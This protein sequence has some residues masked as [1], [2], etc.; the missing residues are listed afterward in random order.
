[1]IDVFNGLIEQ[2]LVPGGCLVLNTA[3]EADDAHPALRTR[4]Q[5]AIDDW[6]AL[7]TGIVA[8]GIRHGELRPDTDGQALAT[9]LIATLEGGVMLSKLYGDG[10]HM[11]RAADHLSRYLELFA[12]PAPAVDE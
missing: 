4:A 9:V 5:Q 6:R 2:P 12:Q 8:A 7:I 10:T 1:V 3:V 11:R